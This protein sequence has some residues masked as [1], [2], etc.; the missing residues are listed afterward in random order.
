MKFKS[1]Y[2]AWFGMDTENDDK[3]RVNLVCL[4][5]EGGRAKMWTK[6]GGFARWCDQQKGS[7]V[8][9]CHNLEYDLINEFGDD[10]S[11]LN[12][13][14]LKNRLISAKCGNVS[15]LD[16]FNHFR[17]PLSKIGDAIGL[18]KLKYDPSNPDY[19]KRDALIAV[20]AMTR[21]RD[22]IEGLGGRIGATAG[23]SAMSVW[24]SM[25]DD[26]YLIG[27]I[28]GAFHR[29]A[30]YG[31]RVEIFKTH[32]AGVIH[33]FDVNSMY[34]FVMQNAFPLY[35]VEDRGL[36]ASKGIAHALVEVPEMQIAPLP[37][38]TD[39]GPLL[40][41][42]GK[43]E[44]VWT[45]DELRHAQSVGAKI[46]KVKRA[47]GGS[48]T[49]KPFKD[50]IQRLY[51]MRLEARDDS[52]KLFVKTIMNSLYGKF[53]SKNEMTRVVSRYKMTVEKD[54][55]VDEV[56]WITHER[57]LLTYRTP[58][59]D[60]V[61]VPWG[62]Y[63]TSYARLVLQSYLRRVPTDRLLYCDTDSVY[64]SGNFRFPESAGLGGMKLERTSHFFQA[65]QPKAYQMG[66]FYKAKGVPGRRVDEMGIMSR[67]YAREYI[68]GGWTC[69]DAPVRFRES[70]RRRDGVKANQWISKTRERKSAYTAKRRQGARYFPPVV[71]RD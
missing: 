5:D 8:V 18:P 15:F 29:S 70:L 52:E 37:Y 24:R 13:L 58:P 4:V 60:F 41:P 35:L 46:L 9:V 10:Y 40:Y 32:D 20:I 51:A 48:V 17:M 11:R 55:R 21:A 28:D 34:P 12:L 47:M 27:P 66:E 16:S 42:V 14:Y 45:Y 2:D 54:P 67:D 33:G 23:S 31:G 6:P 57:G 25:T 68:E 39:K 44:G 49:V 26:D 63:I 56:L 22:F 3:G 30:Y 64:T 65:P 53:A 19:V 59:Q 69:F 38:R 62:A 36:N 71:G 43:F 1:R 61:I 7:P 50:F